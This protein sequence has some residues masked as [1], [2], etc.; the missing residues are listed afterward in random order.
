MVLLVLAAIGMA[1]TVVLV[2]GW[3]DRHRR[4]RHGSVV[5]PKVWVVASWSMWANVFLAGR[6]LRQL[7]PDPPVVWWIA[8]PVI[9][10]V[11]VSVLILI[12]WIASGLSAGDREVLPVALFFQIA[13]VADALLALWLSPRLLAM[14]VLVVVVV[15]LGTIIAAVRTPVRRRAAAPAATT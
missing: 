11:T 2:R 8:V 12:V 6:G 15:G 3:R 10:F 5:V 9:L 14:G 7:E 13:V 1:A 4:P